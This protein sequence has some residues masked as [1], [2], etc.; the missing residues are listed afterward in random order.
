ME[1]EYTR[2]TQFGE[3]EALGRDRWELVAVLPSS[4]EGESVFY[5]KRPAPTF[6]EQVTLEQKRHY[7]GLMGIVDQK[8]EQHK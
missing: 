2:C 7:Y 8:E 5:L 4:A 1:W 6:R 3:L